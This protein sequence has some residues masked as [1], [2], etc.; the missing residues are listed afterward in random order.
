MESAGRRG[1]P[2]PNK[3]DRSYCS[4]MKGKNTKDRLLKVA[5]NEVSV[6]GLSG[7]TLGQLA[8]ASGLSKSGLFAHFESK[9]RLQV[10]LLDHFQAVAQRTIVVPA[11]SAAPGLPRLH[12]LLDLW[13]GWP[14]R[15]GLSGGCA[16]AAAL[17]ELDDLEGGVR[18]HVRELEAKWR[19]MLGRLVAEA[20]A[21]GHLRPETDVDQL[22]W[23]L[24]GIYLFHHVATRFVRDDVAAGARARTALAALIQR[25]SPDPG[26]ARPQD[27][28]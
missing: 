17:F 11:M 28:A 19:Q 1:G 9:E 15:A 16:L 8:G 7:L 26:A 5:L 10:D 4:V 23:E 14:A 22:V 3:H 21:E 2:L 18:D 12:A 27:E 20:V 24:C 25:H 13:F 6:A